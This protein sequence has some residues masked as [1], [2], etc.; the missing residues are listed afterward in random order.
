M[1][2][3]IAKYH[4]TYI[5]PNQVH[6]ICIFSFLYVCTTAS[7]WKHGSLISVSFSSCYT[8]IFHFLYFVSLSFTL[9]NVL[10]KYCIL[11]L[12]LLWTTI[13][14]LLDYINQY[15]QLPNYFVSF[16]VFHIITI[17][18]VIVVIY[19]RCCYCYYYK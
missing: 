14:R 1:K 15:F 19:Y 6:V 10:M 9:N 17:I 13:S 11:F 8:S 3:Y 16:S 12:C 5:I 7:Y 4:Q 2:W 18:I